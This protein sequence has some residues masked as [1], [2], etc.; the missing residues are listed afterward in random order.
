MLGALG[1]AGLAALALWLRKRSGAARAEGARPA[2][3]LQRLAAIE[4]RGLSDPGEVQAAY[5]QITAAVREGIDARLGAD[6]AG[7]TGRA[8]LTDDEWVAALAESDSLSAEDL[9]LLA[10]LL[11]SCA[12]VKYG[13]ARP[14]HWAVEEVLGRARSFLESS[15]VRGPSDE[16]RAGSAA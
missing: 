11:G 16:P 1:L 3:P 9:D 10:D 15:P 5:F 2:T 13:G 4:P 14:T 7:R 8:G 12:A 6:R